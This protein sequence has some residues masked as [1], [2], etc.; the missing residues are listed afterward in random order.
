[1]RANVRMMKRCDKVSRIYGA[2][3]YV[4]VRWKDNH[5]HYNST[6]DP[7]F[8][9]SETSLVSAAISVNRHADVDFKKEKVYPR[10]VRKTPLDFRGNGELADHAP[11]GQPVEDAQPMD[12]RGHAER[13]LD[14]R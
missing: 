3:I 2:D 5:Y 4:L 14:L 11:R 10:P 9:V 1:M 6:N 7:S 12:E 8:P 13:A